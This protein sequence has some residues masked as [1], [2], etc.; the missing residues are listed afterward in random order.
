MHDSDPKDSF[1]PVWETA[2][3]HSTSLKAILK[4]RYNQ[5]QNLPLT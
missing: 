3:A 2:E 5:M 1:K 4:H